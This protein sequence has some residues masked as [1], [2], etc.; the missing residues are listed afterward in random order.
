[1]A[2]FYEADF[3]VSKAEKS[4]GVSNLAKKVAERWLT[5]RVWQKSQEQTT[6]NYIKR[7]FA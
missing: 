1:M 7:E 5:F 4:H 3:S 6:V 2:S